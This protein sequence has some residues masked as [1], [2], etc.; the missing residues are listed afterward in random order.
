MSVPGKP[1]GACSRP[2]DY[3]LYL[4]PQTRQDFNGY[5]YYFGVQQLNETTGNR[6][7]NRKYK[8]QVSGHETGCTYISAFRHDLKKT[9]FMFSRCSNPRNYWKHFLYFPLTGRGK[10]KIS[11]TCLEVLMSSKKK[12]N[13]YINSLIK[14]H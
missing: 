13:K 6:F 3:T 10:S 12:L 5:I 7:P 1:P 2:N 8:I 11:T 14:Y 4:G 9:I